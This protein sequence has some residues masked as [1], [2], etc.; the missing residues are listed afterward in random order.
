MANWPHPG[1]GSAA[2]ATD[3]RLVGGDKGG[4]RIRGLLVEIRGAF[5]PLISSLLSLWDFTYKRQGFVQKKGPKVSL[6]FFFIFR[7]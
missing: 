4:P 2:Q 5:A 3:P 1:R 6:S 7:V